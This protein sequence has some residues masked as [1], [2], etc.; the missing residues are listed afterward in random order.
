MKKKYIQ[1]LTF[2]VFVLLLST[3]NAISQEAREKDQVTI[4]SVVKGG[5]DRPV[6]G[7]FNIRQRRRCYCKRQTKQDNFQLLCPNRLIY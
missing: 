5:D 6:I 3:V 4:Q 2:L 7:A 1:I